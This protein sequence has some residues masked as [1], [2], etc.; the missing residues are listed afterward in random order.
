MNI[1]P[2]HE[3]PA[4]V[5]KYRSWFNPYHLRILTDNELFLSPPNDFNDPF[6]C[7]IST[8]FGLLDNKQK[9]TDYVKSLIE[10]QMGEI[11]RRSL[12]P[13]DE[14]DRMMLR[15]DDIETYQREAD[16][17]IFQL[18]NERFGVLSLS[19][20][21]NNILM[22]SHYGDFHKGICVGFHEDKLRDSGLFGRGG[23]V[24][25][26]DDYPELYPGYDSLSDEEAT[27]QKYFKQTYFKAKDWHYE[28]EYRLMT[29]FPFNPTNQDRTIVIPDDCFAEI[30]L[31]IEFPIDKEREL[32]QIA[33]NKGISIYR[34]IRV[35]FKF[36]IDRVKLV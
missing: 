24:I 8:N 27:L 12:N 34:A 22:W 9:K 28:E 11:L 31:G 19:A 25:Y 16:N 18:Q 21:W 36:A 10:R 20:I 7:R 3:Y 1:T 17:I 13:Q 26:T 33:K 6:D 23:I 14:F 29:T 15:L 30:I 35:P 4:L 32:I 5:Y 2:Q